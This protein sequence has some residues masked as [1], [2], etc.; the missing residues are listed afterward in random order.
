MR[1]SLAIS[2]VEGLL[3]TRM[4][5]EVFKGGEVSPHYGDAP[6]WMILS[7]NPDATRR[8]PWGIGHYYIVHFLNISIWK[9]GVISIVEARFSKTR[10]KG[11]HKQLLS[12]CYHRIACFFLLFPAF[13]AC[14]P[15]WLKKHS[16]SALLLTAFPCGK[17]LKAPWIFCKCIT[18]KVQTYWPR[19]IIK[20]KVSWQKNLR[21]IRS[22]FLD[23]EGFDSIL[24]GTKALKD[25]P[26]WCIRGNNCLTTLV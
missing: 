16:Y 26:Y 21:Q 17:Q 4:K 25:L 22:I 5:L 1:M 14:R 7:P 15:N 8:N 18:W 3:P 10:Q 20:F 2:R 24:K 23:L 9:K 6:L 11:L 12:D 19:P 13:I